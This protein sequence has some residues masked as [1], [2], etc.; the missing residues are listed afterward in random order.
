LPEE[1]QKKKEKKKLEFRPKTHCWV[2]WLL[3]QS[4]PR[5]FVERR[6]A[7]RLPTVA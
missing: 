7:E 3:S 4:E 2:Q 1:K 5:S 6:G